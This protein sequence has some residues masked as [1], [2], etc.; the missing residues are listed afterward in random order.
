[1]I[2]VARFEAQVIGGPHN[3]CLVGAYFSKTLISSLLGSV[4]LALLIREFVCSVIDCRE[5]S[6]EFVVVLWL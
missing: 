1:V 6:K 5:I 3:S 2:K 4:N